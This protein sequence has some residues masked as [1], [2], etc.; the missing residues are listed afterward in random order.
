MTVQ[1]ALGDYQNALKTLLECA[2]S[3]DIPIHVAFSFVKLIDLEKTGKAVQNE[4]REAAIQELRDNY[5]EGNEKIYTSNGYDYEVRSGTTRFAFSDVEEVKQKS[6]EVKEIQEKYKNA[7]KAR[8]KNQMIVNEETG[9]V[10]DVSKVKVTYTP[11]VL[12][13]RKSKS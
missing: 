5:L 4:I 6:K 1:Q 7:W 9:E 13:I 11:D 3:G 12:V 2:M 8:Q 10:L